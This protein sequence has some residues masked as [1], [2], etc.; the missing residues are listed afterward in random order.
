MFFGFSPSN[1]I[2]MKLA[3]VELVPFIGLVLYCIAYIAVLAIWVF[4]FGETLTIE[5]DE[6]GQRRVRTLVFCFR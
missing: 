6:K 1:A 2:K 5:E 4:S 3:E